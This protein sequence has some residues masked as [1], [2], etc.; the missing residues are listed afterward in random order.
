MKAIVVGLALHLAIVLLIAGWRVALPNIGRSILV[1][2]LVVV[3]VVGPLMQLPD[4]RRYLRI[5]AM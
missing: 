4:M 3:F 2:A 1:G 5:R